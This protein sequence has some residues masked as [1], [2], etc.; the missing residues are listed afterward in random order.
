MKKTAQKEKHSIKHPKIRQQKTEVPFKKNPIQK[1]QKHHQLIKTQESITK[2]KS[3]KSQVF[4][5]SFQRSELENK[6]RY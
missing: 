6:K 1:K 2:K 5:I 3:R 4:Q